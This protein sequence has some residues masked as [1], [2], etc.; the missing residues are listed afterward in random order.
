MC[1]PCGLACRSP[2]L[3]GCKADGAGPRRAEHGAL[4]G[5][6][7]CSPETA[8]QHTAHTALGL[9]LLLRQ[10]PQSAEPGRQT[11]FRPRSPM[12]TAVQGPKGPKE[13]EDQMGKRSRS[14]RS[15]GWASP[16]DARSNEGLQTHGQQT[17]S[18]SGS[19]IS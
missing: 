8:R 19:S 17:P 10:A 15:P 1:K 2:A 14:E 16:P 18:F 11:D 6:L 9:A 12:L 4:R 13:P 3:L 5:E 7:A